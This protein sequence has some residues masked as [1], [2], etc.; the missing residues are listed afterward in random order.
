ML[1]RYIKDDMINLFELT[2][3]KLG[4]TSKSTPEAS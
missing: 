3:D 4:V 1:Y 2:V